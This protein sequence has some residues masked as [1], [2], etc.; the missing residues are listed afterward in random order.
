M[1]DC[2][3]RR[4]P[5]AARCAAP[6]T[7]FFP[8]SFPPRAVS[9]HKELLARVA[10]RAAA[11]PSPTAARNPAAGDAAGPG[12]AFSR[13]SPDDANLLIAFLLHSADLCNPL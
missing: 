1:W 12:G 2:R 9:L 4:C 3:R 5:A 13:C 6:L 7:P 8:P 10:E 11:A